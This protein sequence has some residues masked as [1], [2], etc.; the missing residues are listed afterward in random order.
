MRSSLADDQ[1]LE[2]LPW[3][4]AIVY[5]QGPCTRAENGEQYVLSYHCT[6]LKVPKLEAFRSLT[7]GHF[8]RTLSACVFKARIIP[9]VVRTDRGP[10]MR[11]KVMEEFL[12]PCGAR[13]LKGLYILR[14]IRA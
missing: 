12:A 11:S 3:T 14:S 8:G 4:D 9:D 6:R 13:H 7:A 1:L 2:V 5:V 10:E